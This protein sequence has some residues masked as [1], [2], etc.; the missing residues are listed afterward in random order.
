MTPEQIALIAQSIDD[1]RADSDAVVARF[2]DR[3]FELAPDARELF[4]IDMPTQRTKFFRELD[5][6]AHAIPDLDAFVTRAT[7]LGLEHVDFGVE[8]R[9]YR[10]FGQALLEV[11]GEWY[12]DRF[13]PEL[14]DAWRLAYRMVSDSMQRGAARMV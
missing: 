4:M 9:H 13:T 6:I 7:E 1:L 2:Y 14:A 3:L 8:T 10:A 5:E 11:L 12:G